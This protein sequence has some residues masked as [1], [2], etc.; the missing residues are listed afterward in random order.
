MQGRD[1]RLVLT[2]HAASRDTRD[3]GSVVVGGTINPGHAMSDASTARLDIVPNVN[4]LKILR[5]VV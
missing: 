2:D 4:T 1:S 5:S 3:I